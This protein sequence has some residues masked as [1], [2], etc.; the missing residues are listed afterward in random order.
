MCL[1]SGSQFLTVPQPKSS[2]LAF[3][4][5]AIR[6]AHGIRFF[7]VRNKRVWKLEK[8]QELL[9]PNP[10]LSLPPKIL[11]KASKPPASVSLCA[12]LQSHPSPGYGRTITVK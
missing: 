2:L 7:L 9:I 11:G 4:L 8:R 5:V 3:Q 1:A 12:V 10:A 6:A